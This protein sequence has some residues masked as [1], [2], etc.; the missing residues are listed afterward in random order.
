MRRL[1]IFNIGYGSLGLISTLLILL[2]MPSNPLPTSV[3]LSG[4]LAS[5]Y[6]LGWGI[7]LLVWGD[8]IVTAVR[9]FVLRTIALA[10]DTRPGRAVLSRTRP[11]RDAFSR[12]RARLPRIA[13]RRRTAP[14]SSGSERSGV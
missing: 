12:I 7:V 5:A 3:M 10:L 6:I 11:L 8:R 4:G 1:A 9:R 13:R 14:A 2:L